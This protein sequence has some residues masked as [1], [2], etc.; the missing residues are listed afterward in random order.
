VPADEIDG[1][2][3]HFVSCADYVGVRTLLTGD[4]SIIGGGDCDDTNATIYPDAP[5]VNDAVDNQ[6]PGDQG[7]GMVDELSGTSGF[8]TPGDTE[9][10]SWPAQPGAS[11]YEVARSGLAD[12]SG[13]CTTWITPDTFLSDTSRPP[14]TSAFH[15]LTRPFSPNTGSWGQDSVLE[16]SG[17]TFQHRNP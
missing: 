13:V 17:L 15:Y 6:C 16:G 9:T 2:K 1:D 11:Q 8:N 3:D 12:L 4:P 14:S 5:E 7:F 10:Y